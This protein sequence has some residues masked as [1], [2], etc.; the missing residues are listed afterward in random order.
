MTEP[1]LGEH[2]EHLR[3]RNQRPMSIRARRATVLRA[4]GWLAHPVAEVTAAELQ[5]WRAGL[6]RLRPASQYVAVVHVTQFLAWCFLNGHRADNP[7]YVLVRPKLRK[8]LPR[9]M[10]DDAIGQAMAAAEQPLRAWIALGAFCGLR[11]M[12]IASVRRE[13]VIDSGLAPFL[14]VVGKGDKERIVP[15]P[16]AVL[17]ELRAAGMTSASG[18]LW[19]LPVAEIEEGKRVSRVINAHLLALG[20]EGTAH[21]LRHR[22]GTRLYEVTRDLA[23]VATV[24]G[25]SSTET[26]M[27][28]VR[29]NPGAASL[30]IEQISRLGQVVGP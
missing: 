9:P 21:M 16:A 25:H 11:C 27:G 28:Y 4:A 14:R 8:R 29:I 2:L 24:M 30:P 18:P 6:M 17:I 13:D 26:T 10:N 7:S 23:L 3:Q 20:I 15:L 5:A 12:E 1:L 22:F 19:P